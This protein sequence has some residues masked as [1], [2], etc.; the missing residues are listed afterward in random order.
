MNKSIKRIIT[1]AP[2]ATPT[3]APIGTPVEAD[4]LE[5][6][7]SVV[8]VLCAAEV[9]PAIVKEVFG[10]VAIKGSQYCWRRFADSDGQRNLPIIGTYKR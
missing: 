6:C 5:F 10:A 9:D 3:S 7:P 2:T 8:V 1:V 4:D